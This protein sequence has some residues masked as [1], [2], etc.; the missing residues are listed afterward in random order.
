MD[1]KVRIGII[2]TGQIGKHHLRTYQGI[3][4]AEVVAACDLR[5]DELERVAEA[6]DIPSTYTDY[7]EMLRRDDIHSVDVC[8]HNRLH[9][10]VTIDAL[11]AGKNVYCEKPMSWTYRDARA[12]YDTAEE[13][14]RMLHIQLSTL[15]QPS[16]RAAKRLI[17]E[18]HLGELYYAKSMHYRRRGRPYVDGY[19]SQAFVSTETSGGG[20]LLDMAVY[21]I[22]RILYLLG[23]PDLVS[24]SGATHQALDMYEKRRRGSG[25][26]VE[27]L[28][29]AY[30]RLAGDIDL[31]ME[32]AWAIHSDDPDSDYVYG[33]RGGLRVEPPTYYTTVAD[34]EM[35]GR[36]DVESADLRW[37][38]TDPTAAYYADSQEHWVAAQLGRIPLLDTAGIALKT[39]LITE[40]I[41]ISSHLGREVTA[42][43]IEEAEPG[44]GRV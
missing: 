6:F 19:G 21:H 5:E 42:K 33:S 22:A 29:M 18:G 30:I 43:E 44:L 1:E 31:F 10:P 24:V 32:E 20:A 28:G 27:E 39:S 17:D 41:Y 12:M 3:P 34:V 36:L 15:Y 13:L 16:T 38:R 2:G 23:N 26:D 25:Y 4:E 11:E 7:H 9:R 35:N 37:R 8:V 14:G 40:G